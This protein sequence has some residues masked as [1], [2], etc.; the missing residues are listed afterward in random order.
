LEGKL[1][2]LYQVG[3]CADVRLILGAIE[4]GARIGMKI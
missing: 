3:D 1:P 4:D 2:N